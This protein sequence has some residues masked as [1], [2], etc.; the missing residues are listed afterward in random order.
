MSDS[1]IKLGV[2]EHFSGH[3]YEVTGFG[4]HVLGDG[5]D[6]QVGQDAVVYH[7]LFHSPAYGDR[8]TWVRPVD[9]FVE[10]VDVEGRRVPRFRYV[11]DH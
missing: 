9:N 10:D 3:L 6:E 1:T 4:H 2:Y 7:A 11:G 5:M 8:H